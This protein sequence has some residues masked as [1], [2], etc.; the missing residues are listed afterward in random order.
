MVVADWPL[1]AA[2]MGARICTKLSKPAHIARRSAQCFDH[3]QLLA[4]RANSEWAAS[5]A[6]PI[7][8][9]LGEQCAA[10]ARRGRGAGGVHMA[11]LSLMH[12]VMHIHPPLLD[13]RPLAFE[14]L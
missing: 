13:R 7:E 6:R 8:F 5:A 11:S 10:A 12:Q 2:I 4:F 3:G 9:C 14:G 1:R